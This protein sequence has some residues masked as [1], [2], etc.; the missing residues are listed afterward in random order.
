MLPSPIVATPPL[1]VTPPAVPEAA[2]RWRGGPAAGTGAG[3]WRGTADS[4]I[5]GPEALAAG[6]CCAWPL[7]LDASCARIG[8][9]VFREAAAGLGLPDDQ[10][11]DGV[12]MTSELAANTLH[13]QQNVQFDGAARLPVAGGPE[14][15][16]YLRRISGRWE[17]VCKVFDSL[18]GWKDGAL[19]QPGGAGFQAVGGRG[20]QVVAGLCGGRWGHHLSRSRLSAWKVPG[21]VVW[22]AQPVPAGCVPARLQRARLRPCQAARRLEAMLVDRGLGGSLLCADET[23]AGISVLSVRRGLTVWCR[24]DQVSWRTRAG[25]Y[26]QRVLTDLQDA[27]EQIVCLCEELD[28]GRA[29]GYSGQDRVR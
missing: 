1:A 13:A 6:G 20:L 3:V 12:T 24:A 25:T 15:W 9:Q 17:L 21:K 26:E 7:P 11:Y 2:G 27:V 19:P 5:A 16:L 10:I 8:R 14:L 28:S 23:A 29:G 4:L 18:A 22:F